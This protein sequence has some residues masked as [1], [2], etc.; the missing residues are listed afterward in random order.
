MG[1]SIEF[2]KNKFSVIE[3]TRIH[4][5]ILLVILLCL[6]IIPFHLTPSEAVDSES[7]TLQINR[8]SAINITNVFCYPSDPQ[9]NE[10]IFIFADITSTSNLQTVYLY[11]RILGWGGETWVGISMDKC[12]ELGHYY[13][14]YPRPHG[15]PKSACESNN[16]YF[17][18]VGL[19]YGAFGGVTLEYYI[20][21][22]STVEDNNGEYYKVQ[23]GQDTTPPEI[24]DVYH[25][26]ITP[27]SEDDI[28]VYANVSDA[29]GLSS[30]MVYYQFNGGPWQYKIM[31]WYRNS[32]L[33]ATIG[34]FNSGD[35][36]IYYINATDKSSQKNNLIEDNE[37]MYYTIGTIPTTAIATPFLNNLILTL[38]SITLVLIIKRR[39]VQTTLK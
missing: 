15:F 24:T 10:T 16:T 36:I 32:T 14:I 4:H 29:S 21:V 39:R 26:P 19:G 6:I 9:V 34:V 22:G 35:G 18:Q 25:T 37:G 30:V 12:S 31:E 5:K 27:Q 17:G 38:T 11:R 1:T 3:R 28:T 23:I 33:K 2:M 13:W 8:S 7:E 20:K